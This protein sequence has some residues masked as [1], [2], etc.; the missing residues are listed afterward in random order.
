[1]LPVGASSE[2]TAP[3]CE[4]PYINDTHNHILLDL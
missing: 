1:M 3:P 2:S 4:V